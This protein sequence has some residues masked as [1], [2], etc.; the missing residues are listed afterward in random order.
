MPCQ[1]ATCCIDWTA[2]W[3]RSYPEAQV[4]KLHSSGQLYLGD[5]S[6]SG[7]F[8]GS[9]GSSIRHMKGTAFPF[10]QNPNCCWNNTAIR[11]GVHTQ[12]S[13]IEWPGGGFTTVATPAGA[14]T[15]AVNLGVPANA[16]TVT[17][18]SE[19]ICAQQRMMSCTAEFVA[20]IF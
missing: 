5:G 17:S 14:W 7:P 13:T 3:K 20:D 8:V 4:L 11:S 9:T 19:N 10:N 6:A 1:H 16:A 15:D 2:P 12:T 18:D